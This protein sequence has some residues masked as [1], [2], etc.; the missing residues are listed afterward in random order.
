MRDE[1]WRAAD[2][3]EVTRCS[4]VYEDALRRNDVATL[5][6]LFWDDPTVL[7]FGVADWQ[8][9]HAAVR[10]WRATAPPVSP[11]RMIRERHVIALAPGVVAVDLIFADDATTIGRQSQTWVRTDAGWRIARAHVSVIPTG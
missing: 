9:G 5:D 11:D 1:A 10:T 2:A 4:D 6:E 7:R 3:D 8:R